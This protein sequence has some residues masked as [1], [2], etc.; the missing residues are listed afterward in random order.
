MSYLKKTIYQGR[1]SAKENELFNRILLSGNN[2]WY[3]IS[4]AVMTRTPAQCRAHYQKSQISSRIRLIKEKAL[5]KPINPISIQ[6]PNEKSLQFC[7]AT[8]ES[9]P[10]IDGKEI[11]EM[12][13]IQETSKFQEVLED[14]LLFLAFESGNEEIYDYVNF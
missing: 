3:E 13:K 2:N 6:S 9:T 8:A 5:N 10:E 12:Q 7:L 4:A 11:F 1:W 14:E